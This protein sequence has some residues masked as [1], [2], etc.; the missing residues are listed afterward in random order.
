MTPADRILKAVHMAIEQERTR[1]DSGVFKVTFEVFVK[2]DCCEVIPTYAG[3][4][5][6]V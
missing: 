1:L 4:R 6:K 3:H 5:V 2:P